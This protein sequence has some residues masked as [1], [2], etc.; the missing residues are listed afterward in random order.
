M[1]YF[2]IAGEASGDLHGAHLVKAIK[3]LDNQASLQAWGGDAMQEQGCTVLKHVRELAFM[4]FVE[5]LK[6]LKTILG[7]I[8]LCKQQIQNFKPDVVIFIDYPG[9]NLRLA[10]WAKENN[11]KTVYYISPQ[12]WAWK[13]NR[14]HTIKKYVDEMICI[15]P[16]EKEFY[17]KY[18]VDVHYV[19]HPLA[20]IIKNYK[21]NNAPQP[22]GKKTIALLPGSR[23]QEVNTKLPIMLSIIKYYPTYNFVIAQSPTLDADVYKPF[24][25]TENVSLV[26]N[27]TYQILNNAYAAIVTSGTATLETA[28]FNVPQVVCYIGNT[29]SYAI[30]KRLI[31]VKYISLVNLIAN[32]MVV[33]ELI[34]KQVNEANLKLAVDEILEQNH[35]ENVLAAYKVLQTKLQEDGA[36]TKAA[37]II[38]KVV[39]TAN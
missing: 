30:G 19:G 5:V 17:K 22:T 32:K 25:T 26:K 11:Y 16:F 13:E 12:I 1:K 21:Q 3:V 31:K 24:I 2:I 20:E 37:A 8:S 14:V 18:E 7:N 33:K 35:R 15:L 27:N 10:K 34:Q 29:L 9:F 36:A 28:L 39:N 38:N 6:N 23:L 4:G